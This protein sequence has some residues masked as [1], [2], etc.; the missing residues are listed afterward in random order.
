MVILKRAFGTLQK[1]GKALMLPVSV[2]PVAGLLLGFGAS[3]LGIMPASVSTLMEQ[4]GGALFSSL[5]LLFAIATAV[6][7]AGNDGV[8]ALAA[9]VGFVVML[10]T[11]G[12]M[13]HI[14][15]VKPA[16][17]MGFKS[18]DTGVFGGILIGGVAA[19]LFNRYYRIQ[20]PQYLGFFAG[21]RFVPIV[22]AFAAIAIGIVLSFIWP[23]IQSGID[24][25]SHAAAYGSP[26]SAAAIYGFV[27][28]LLIPFGLHHIWNVPFFFEIGSYTEASGQ[29]VH[30]DITRF[31]A[32]DPSAGILGGAYLFKMFGLPAAGLAIWNC[33][34]PENKASVGSL[35]VSA[36]LTSFLMGITEP[37]EFS[38][39]FVAPLL[40]AIHAVLVALGQALFGLLG[41]RLGFTFS[42]GFMDYVLWFRMDTKPWLVLVIGPFWG[43]LYYWVFRYCIL[44]FDLKTPGREDSEPVIATP[45]TT[46]DQKAIELVRA[47]GGRGNIANLDACITRLRVEV[48]DIS[49][50]SVAR[51]KAL[52]ASGVLTVGNNVQAVFGP[53]SENLKSAMET[54]LRG[55]DPVLN[56][57]YSAPRR[58][59]AP[60]SPA[61]NGETLNEADAKRAA[62]RWLVG[63]GGAANIVSAEACAGSRIRLKLKDSAA[64]HEDALVAAGVLG[65]MRLQD[66]SFHLIVGPAA[67]DYARALKGLLTR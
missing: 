51:L 34:K 38:F 22:T 1:I 39:L 62:T 18:M 59:A 3:K 36:A 60:I 8:A 2:L 47:F 49:R 55:E 66:Q 43:L 41:A 31:F 10:A 53:N 6:G 13:A 35:M 57:S 27:E 48:N 12:V 17:V 28:R 29:V 15:G 54:A 32:G 46:G 21:K 65:V 44:R 24:V 16:E 56:E 64:L 23:P 40:Y 30:G 4:S 37:L 9:S 63:L 5:P 58:E 52:G 11:M 42:Q 14:L 20:L 45:A 61:A 19:S 33:A 50:A 67:P 25:I 7:L 26:T